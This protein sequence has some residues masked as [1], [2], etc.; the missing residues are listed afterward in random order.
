MIF[1]VATPTYVDAK[2]ER[3]GKSR[4]VKNTGGELIN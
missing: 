2:A 3:N 1:Y 4:K